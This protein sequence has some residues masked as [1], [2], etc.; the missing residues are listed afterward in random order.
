MHWQGLIALAQTI[1]PLT[2]A[3]CSGEE[4]VQNSVYGIFR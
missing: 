4:L 1:S 3:A 2:F